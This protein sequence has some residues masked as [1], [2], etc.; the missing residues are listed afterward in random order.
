LASMLMMLLI[1]Y[2][3]FQFVRVIPNTLLYIN[4]LII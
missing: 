2:V 3:S 4:K 1:V